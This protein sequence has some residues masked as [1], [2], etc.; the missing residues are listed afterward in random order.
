MKSAQQKLVKAS[1][2][3]LASLETA[4][5]ATK[6]INPSNS[7]RMVKNMTEICGLVEEMMDCKLEEMEK[8]Y[9]RWSN[10]HDFI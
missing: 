5:E 10:S 6:K 3:A 1:F 9:E 4:I 8:N 7:A 2:E